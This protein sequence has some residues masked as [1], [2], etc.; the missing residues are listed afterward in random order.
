MGIITEVLWA[1]E[2]STEPLL[3]QDF[4]EMT[5]AD[6]EKQST[7]RNYLDVVP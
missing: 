6:H 7:K 4:R 5:K 1:L 2:L 3:K